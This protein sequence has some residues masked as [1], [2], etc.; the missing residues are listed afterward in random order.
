[1]VGQ[2]LNVIWETRGLLRR[3]LNGPHLFPQMS[4][5]AVGETLSLSLSVTWF[6]HPE[7]VDGLIENQAWIVD[8][9]GRYAAATV[10]GTLS[11]LP[12]AFLS[13]TPDLLRHYVR[14]S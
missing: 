6:T 10:A 14:I 4:K 7:R 12:L 9:I 3:F 11:N 13:L 1:M 8:C 5:A 2:R